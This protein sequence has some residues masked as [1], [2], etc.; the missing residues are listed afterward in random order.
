VD[1]A[2]HKPKSVHG[3]RELAIEIGVIVI[4]VVIA[5][6]LEQAVEVIRRHPWIGGV[7]RL[8]LESEPSGYPADTGFSSTAI[9][10]SSASPMFWT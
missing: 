8:T 3:M 10:R 6:G 5:I 1:D 9:T 2:L 4:G 7:T